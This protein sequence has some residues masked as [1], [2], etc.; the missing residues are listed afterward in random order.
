MSRPGRILVLRRKAVG[1]VVVSLP[2]AA[3]LRRAWP[4][5]RLE[6]VV[7]RPA[8]ALVEAAGVVDEVLIPPGGGLADLAWMGRLRRRAYDLVLDLMGTP[9]TARWCA[10]TGAAVRVGRRRRHR[11]WAYNHIVEPATG[12]PRFAGE[13]FLDLARAVGASAEAWRPVPLGPSGGALQDP[14]PPGRGPWVILVPAATWPAKAWPDSHFAK[15]T[16]ILR[17]DGIERIEVAWGPGEE[18]QRDRIV[19]AAAGAARPM[20]PTGLLELAR[21]LDACDLVVTTDSGPKHVAVAQ[22]PP[23]LT[24]FGSTDPAGWQPDLPGH[25][26]LFHEVECRPCNLRHCPV[27]GHPCLDALAPERV[28]RAA[29]ALLDGA[30]V[31]S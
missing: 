31:A 29:R 13:V 14:P 10:A 6:M 26:A 28:H 5:A 4:A 25:G 17:E 9:R 16:Q 15:L 30:E 2:V 21:R 19:A 11:T 20:P 27:P 22:G 7:D 8:A 23:T 18:G 1:D 3:A 24:L 12:R